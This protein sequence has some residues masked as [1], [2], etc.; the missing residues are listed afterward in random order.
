M[1]LFF[2]DVAHQLG[3]D[4]F[5]A[6][7]DEE[8]SPILVYVFDFLPEMDGVE[9]VF[10]QELPQG[11]GIRR[12]GTPRCVRIDRTSRP[13][14]FRSS[15]G[16]DK[17]L[18]GMLDEGGV[19]GRGHRQGDDSVPLALQGLLKGG[20]CRRRAGKHDLLPR[21]H[22]CNDNG[23]MLFD[24][25]PNLFRIPDDRQHAT[26]VEPGNIRS[27]H[28]PASFPCEAEVVCVTEDTGRP[29]GCQFTE[30]VPSD[31][32]GFKS[33]LHQN[34]VQSGRKHADGGLGKLCLAQKLLVRLPLSAVE[35]G[36]REDDLREGNPSVS[37]EEAIHFSVG[38]QNNGEV[39]GKLLA[40][41]E[42]LRALA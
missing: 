39:A 37:H 32:I 14:E 30:A 29:E 23:R 22:V 5:R 15:K 4:A 16:L 40:H 31:K 8:G 24:L 36:L 1:G 34:P 28:G 35:G 20:Q 41:P 17:R 26:C 3:Q 7:L 33:G 9:K 2:E 25:F 13:S 27:R 6:E 12:I 10:P 38:L 42:N 19:K 18:L 21:I 11:L